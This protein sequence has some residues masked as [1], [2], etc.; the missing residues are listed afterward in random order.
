MC[1]A[2][3][4]NGCGTPRCKENGYTCADNMP[5]NGLR[6]CSLVQVNFRNQQQIANPAERGAFHLFS[7]YCRILTS[8]RGFTNQKC[9]LYLNY[10]LYRYID[11]EKGQTFI[12]E[13]LSALAPHMPEILNIWNDFKKVV[14]F[15]DANKAWLIS[16]MQ[17]CEKIK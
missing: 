15:I 7:L 3:V 4:Q 16:L 9:Q 1:P 11:K 8:Y 17:V 6:N 12:S 13:D 5:W 2:G 10:Y 14:E